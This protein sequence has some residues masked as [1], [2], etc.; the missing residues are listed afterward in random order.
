MHRASSAFVLTT[1]TAS[2]VDLCG[3]MPSEGYDSDVIIPETPEEQYGEEVEPQAETPQDEAIPNLDVL[4]LSGAAQQY[5]GKRR[6]V[7]T[8]RATAN[9]LRKLAV[10]FV[11]KYASDK[12]VDL[13]E[14]YA[15]DPD[16]CAS[17]L[18]QVFFHKCTEKKEVPIVNLTFI[19]YYLTEFVIS[20]RR[21]DNPA[22][23][24]KP[25]TIL[26]YI[27][28]IQRGF[29][30]WRDGISL[31]P[32]KF[33]N[34]ERHELRAVVNDKLAE[35]QALA[36]RSVSHNAI[37]KS[38]A[39]KIMSCENVSLEN[40]DSY[41]EHLI[42][43]VWLTLGIETTSMANLT[44]QQFQFSSQDGTPCIIYSEQ[45][46]S[47]SGASKTKKGGTAAI[48]VQPLHIFIYDLPL[49]SGA[50]LNPFQT[51]SSYLAISRK[52]GLGHER[53]FLQ[54]KRAKRNIACPNKNRKYSS[55][56]CLWERTS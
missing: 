44:V 20:M 55:G 29:K 28:S 6:N 17:R 32:G 8:D 39:E 54:V 31:L 11:R 45:V 36:F 14:K 34:D 42:F 24:L 3:G 22:T 38:D 37:T 40:A 19:R 53:V 25:I 46:G 50:I 23:E 47:L 52:L 41:L 26:N 30:S 51:I 56:I 2:C 12:K 13:P 9:A 18:H 33:F 16:L 7:N 21:S 4:E 35:Q 5:L 10:F 49:L 27:K 15:K 43:V 1:S 48:G